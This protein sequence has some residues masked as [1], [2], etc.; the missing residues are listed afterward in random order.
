MYLT[1]E[2]YK[3]MGGTLDDTAFSNAE[4][5][6]EYLIHSQAGGQTGERIAKLEELPQALKDCTFDLIEYGSPYFNGKQIA[7]ESQ[8]QGGTSES[9][10]YVTKTSREI[11]AE[12]EQI[13]AVALTGSGYEWLLY[14][15][16]CL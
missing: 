14:R 4:R 6:A 15:G 1:Y 7:S 5:R 8:S 9:Y 3:Q 2:E 10:S 13:I 12:S 11:Y 16:A